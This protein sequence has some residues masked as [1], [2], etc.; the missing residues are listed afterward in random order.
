MAAARA[1]ARTSRRADAVVACAPDDTLEAAV[2]LMVHEGV[3]HVYV[4]EDDMAV[5]VVSCLDVLRVLAGG[6]G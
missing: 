2:R 6:R 1:E 4:V 5:G 3:H